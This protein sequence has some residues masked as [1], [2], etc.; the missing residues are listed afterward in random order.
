MEG[1]IHI[2]SFVGRRRPR[3]AR[4]VANVLDYPGCAGAR[5]RHAS[6]LESLAGRYFDM[7]AHMGVGVSAD[8]EMP[9]GGLDRL[10]AAPYEM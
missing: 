7:P 10:G 5:K 8:S 4:T 3:R 6:A 9:A 2:N 1:Q